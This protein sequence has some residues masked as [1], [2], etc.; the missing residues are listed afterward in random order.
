M[1]DHLPDN[2]MNSLKRLVQT[3]AVSADSS[4]NSGQSYRSVI[5]LWCEVMWCDVMWGDVMWCDVWW[6]E[7]MLGDVRWIEVRWGDV[8]RSSFLDLDLTIYPIYTIYT[9]YTQYTQY[10][11]YTHY[12][13]YSYLISSC[14]L[15][16]EPSNHTLINKQPTGC[17]DQQPTG[18]A[19]DMSSTYSLY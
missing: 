19:E 11:L 16:P 10:T 15:H 18:C 6:G 2:Y 3:S 1:G 5:T 8:C 9:L 12:I 13:H 4:V 17:A 14:L 7:V